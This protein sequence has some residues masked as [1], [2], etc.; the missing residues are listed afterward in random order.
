MYEL[1]KENELAIANFHKGKNA[2]ND[3]EEARKYSEY[4]NICSS[5]SKTI[6]RINSKI[7][8]I[9]KNISKTQQHIDYWNI[10]KQ[11]KATFD[12]QQ[13]IENTINICK[14]NLQELYSEKTVIETMIKQNNAISAINNENKRK[15]NDFKN[16]LDHLQLLAHIYEQYRC[17]LYKEHILPKL[18]N[19]TNRFISKVEPNLKLDYLIKQD[20]SFVFQA[21]NNLQ[22]I[23]LEKT[24][25]FE[26]FILAI[27]LRLAFIS[28]TMG[29]TKFGGQLLIDEGFTYCDTN[30]LS[31]IPGFLESLLN[32]FDSIILVSHLEKIKDSVDNLSLIHI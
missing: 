15:S 27:C 14:L 5:N 23:Q 1:Y 25:G 19:T 4:T 28:L 7:D 21:I 8:Q 22:E 17:W 11:N 16:K 20:S 12:K 13:I 10:V 29:D 3:L 2:F 6:S 18:I 24:S 30:H 9:N 32:N 31:K 26:Y